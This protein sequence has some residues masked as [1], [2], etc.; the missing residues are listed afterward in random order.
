MQRQQGGALQDRTGG[1]HRGVSDAAINLGA[2][3]LCGGEKGTVKDKRKIRSIEGI[4]GL[5]QTMDFVTECAMK[6]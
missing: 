5:L 3:G 2:G 6:P 1:R 4:T